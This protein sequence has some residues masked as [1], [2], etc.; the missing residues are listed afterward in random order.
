M[1]S[2]NFEKYFNAVN[3]LESIQNLPQDDYFVKKTGRSIFL[4]RLKYFLKQIGNPHQG[5]KYIHVGGTSGKGSV[6]NMIQSVLVEAGYKT[7]L[8]TSPFPTTSIEKIKVNNLL[9][10][11]LELAKIVED[12]KPAIDKTYTHSPFGRPSYFE[13]FTTIAFIYFKKQKCDYV[14]LEVGLGGRHDAT[15]IIPVP[16]ITIINKIDYDHT[17]ILGKTLVE[18]TKE[19]AAIIKPKTVFFTSSQ[20]HPTVLKIFRKTCQKNQAE[21]NLVKPA[22]QTYKLNLLGRHQQENAAL[23]TAVCLRL[24]ISENIIK[25]GLSKV[26]LS[27]RTEVIQKNPMVILDGAHNISKLKTT[28]K[29]IKNLTYKKLYTI[30]ALTND[31]NAAQVFK[32]IVSLSDYLFLTRFQ[33]TS[34]K[35]YPPVKLAEKIKSNKQTEIF[36][37]PKM[38]LQKALKLTGKNDLILITGSFYLAGELR[39]HWR[40]EEDILEKRKI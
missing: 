22:K 26:K 29:V 3:Y 21:F 38:A 30:I 10:D 27:C 6:A 37:D 40:S 28:T 13:I 31:R 24:G 16:E 23:A 19:K 20:N 11:P 14:V 8:Y 9:I 7:G 34:R 5:L 12:I 33:N 18:I 39:K 15:N 25:T 2:K 36:L 1:K 17:E 35:C 32:E 4:K